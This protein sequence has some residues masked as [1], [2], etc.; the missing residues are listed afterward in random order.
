MID[1]QF[2]PLS[3][4]DQGRDQGD[5]AAAG[6]ISGEHPF[7][8]RSHR[9]NDNFAKDGAIVVGHDNIRLRLAAGTKAG[10]TGVVRAPRPPEALPKQTYTGGS[11]TLEAGGRKAQLTY[12]ANAHTDGDTWVYF[13]DAMCSAPATR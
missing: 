5:L 12:V 11:F 9:R 6:Q 2:A 3:R 10:L 1:S 4:Q 13:A 8:R 7:P